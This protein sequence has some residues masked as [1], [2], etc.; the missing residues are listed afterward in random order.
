MSCLDQIDQWRHEAFAAVTLK[1]D[2][3]FTEAEGGATAVAGAAV[4]A[5][6]FRIAR[7]RAR[8]V[9]SDEPG[10][11]RAAAEAAEAM[12]GAEVWAQ[13]LVDDDVAGFARKA[14]AARTRP[15]P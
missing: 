7:L 5:H 9:R 11:A 15:V 8:A 4:W 14:V 6:A 2:E 1:A 3:A 13:M 10:V 12:A